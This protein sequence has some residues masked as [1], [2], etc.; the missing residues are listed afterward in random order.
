MHE[1]IRTESRF[2]CM[3][4]EAKQTFP[5]NKVSDP[6]VMMRSSAR[7]T[8]EVMTLHFSP[9]ALLAIAVYLLIGL[10]AGYRYVTKELPGL[11]EAEDDDDSEEVLA[12]KEQLSNEL[13][14]MQRLVGSR[15]LICT[16]FLLSMLFWLPAAVV[17]FFRTHIMRR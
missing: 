8:N 12:A 1:S 3:L 16:L 4:H 9:Y 10:I 5:D 7:T 6:S 13:D 15:G 11:L 2:F 14:R 17:I